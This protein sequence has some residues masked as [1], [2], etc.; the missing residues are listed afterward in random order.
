MPNTRPV[1]RVSITETS[2]AAVVLTFSVVPKSAPF[3]FIDHALK[4]GDS[5]VGAGPNEIRNFIEDSRSLQGELF[6]KQGLQRTDEEYCLERFQQDSRTD[7]DYQLKREALD[8]LEKDN[9]PKAKAGDL[10]AAS[11]L[12][13]DNTTDR[14]SARHIYTQLF[15]DFASSQDAMHEV[16]HIQSRLQQCL[17]GAMPFH[18]HLEFPDIFRNSNPGFDV[19]VGNPP[20]IGGSLISRALNKNYERW[21]KSQIRDY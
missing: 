7:E 17:C 4:C 5:L 16:V 2:C 14:R 3:T 12:L 18:W 8:T 1:Y 20:F 13:H 15:H 6:G 21:L 10:V 19:I 11:F 9:E